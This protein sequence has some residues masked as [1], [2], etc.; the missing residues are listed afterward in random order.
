MRASDSPLRWLIAP[1][2]AAGPELG[3]EFPVLDLKTGEGGL[4]QVTLEGINLKF[5]HNQVGYSGGRRLPAPALQASSV[6]V[7]PPRTRAR[8][9]GLVRASG[10]LDHRAIRGEGAVTLAAP[11]PRS[12]GREAV[13]GGGERGPQRETQLSVSGSVPGPCRLPLL[14]SVLLLV[15][16]L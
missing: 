12:C 13:Q 9:P 4:L 3:G 10:Q 16:S 1:S 7:P 15:V 11:T 6:Q 8:P 2:L 5:M 14:Q